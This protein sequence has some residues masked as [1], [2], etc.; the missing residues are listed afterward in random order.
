MI[1]C[2][3]SALI[4]LVVFSAPV[5]AREDEAIR[6]ELP[7]TVELAM[8]VAV[9]SNLDKDGQSVRREGDYAE[10]VLAHFGTHIDHPVFAAL[11]DSFNLPRLAGNAADF[12]FNKNGEI[13]EIDASGSI[14]GDAEGDLFRRYLPLLKDFA[15]TSDF[16][17][18]YESQ[19]SVYEGG[20]EAMRART[21]SAPMSNW[22]EANFTARPGPMQIIVSPLIGGHNWTTLFKPQTRIW[23]RPPDASEDLS[24]MSD[25]DRVKHASWVFTELDHSFVNPA[26]KEI[27]SQVEPG[28]HNLDVWT[29]TGSSAQDYAS[30]ELQFNE[31]MTWAVYLMFAVDQLPAEDFA[32]LKQDIVSVM[33]EGRG[34]VA[35]EIFAETAVRFYSE[36]GLTAEQIM[37]MM[38]AWAQGYAAALD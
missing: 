25:Y 35:F 3:L 23:V 30:A 5:H 6:F 29:R 8:I 1:R 24:Q 38:A 2:L 18:F 16:L 31:Y 28:F 37:P 34:F 33:V 19:R 14:W 17:N 12:A 13:V 7:E 22:L 4:G 9:V 15:E 10:Q 20:L 32:T 26:T 27:L 21:D 36:E 11:G